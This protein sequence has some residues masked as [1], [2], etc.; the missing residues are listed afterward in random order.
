VRLNVRSS[1]GR[2]RADASDWFAAL[3]S[4]AVCGASTTRTLPGG[5][6]AIS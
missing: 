3:D 2:E 1:K 5:D 4:D 6:V